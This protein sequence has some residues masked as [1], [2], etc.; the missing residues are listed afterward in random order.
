MLKYGLI[1]EQH[2][3]AY[4][5]RQG[6]DLL[7]LPP[8]FALSASDVQAQCGV[9]AFS[10]NT[11]IAPGEIAVLSQRIAPFL[12]AL[13]AALE[14]APIEAVSSQN[15]LYQYHLR[16]QYLFLTALERF[17]ADKR[18]YQLVLA[19]V[20]YRRYSSPMRPELGLL[21][22]NE[23]LLA[24]L[25]LRLVA[26]LGGQLATPAAGALGALRDNLR[27]ACRKVFLGA[28]M[29][30]K[31][32]QKT[33]QARRRQA[34]P[35]LAP[36]Q[37][38]VGFIVRTDS[39]VIA[40]SY[41]I[42]QLRAQGRPFVV[43]HD[44]MLSS[45]TTLARLA[46]LGID[47]ISIGAVHGLA[48]VWRAWRRAPAPLVLRAE[49]MPAPGPGGADAVLF[50]DAQVCAELSARLLD[51]AVAQRHF[52]DE[53][54]ALAQ[55]YQVTCLVTFA[56]VDQWGAV[57]RQV[58]AALGIETVAVQN[59]A[60]DP[61][62]YPRLC[63]ADHYC[64]E[65]LYLKQR[66]VQMGYP[67]ARLSATGLPQFSA[68]AAAPVPDASSAGAHR[69][70]L[71]LT[72]PI[73]REHYE[74]LI[75]ATAQLC[76][77]H[78]VELAIKFH[79]RQPN[80][81]YHGAIAAA[82]AIGPVALFQAEP[83]DALV[84]GASIVVSVVS[85]ALIRAVNLG[86]PSVSFLPLEERHLD[87]YYASESTVFCAPDI[88]AYEALIGQ[89]LRDYPAFHAEALRKRAHYL[90]VHASFEPGAD[91]ARNIVGVI[92]A[93]SVGQRDTVLA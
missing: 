48:G 92:A 55:R 85:A 67:P 9:A 61:E 13:M 91:S 81:D 2:N 65:S 73:Y 72:Q 47:S 75:V 30:A 76:A 41:L 25:A 62:E 22:V 40:A 33:W 63:W 39:E 12:R 87:L 10:L 17:L 42:Q 38:P 26:K 80:T 64:V 82:R 1:L 5:V 78:G 66:L 84:Q 53:L 27:L 21:Y 11:L 19:A 44:E 74:R 50:G 43:F 88:D 89:A 28:F 14:H 29:G 93:H 58:G 90:A 86:T 79:P 77:A 23:K 46:G 59:A 49:A 54:G 69:R 3:I 15:D 16:Y 70:I 35:A 57:I 51:F 18:N 4:L 71:L 45:S 7:L 20:P 8:G 34:V 31:L 24:M 68:V 32:V 37:R 52:A 36:G 83:L 60:Q 6:V 56:Y